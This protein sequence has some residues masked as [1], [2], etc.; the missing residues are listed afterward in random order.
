MLV[1]EDDPQVR[2][3][4]ARCC[5]SSATGCWRRAT[6]PTALRL[7][8]EGA[9]IDLL[10]ADVVLP[11]GMKGSE[12][13]RRMAE[14]RPGLRVLFMSGY[15]ENAIVHHG[16]LDD[17]VQLIGK[18]FQ[19]EHLARRV[20]EVLGR[21][22]ARRTPAAACAAPDRAGYSESPRATATADNVIDLAARARGTQA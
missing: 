19:R 18:P 8:A 15:T 2:E 22:A 16:R 3:V 10:L 14:L 11:G 13:A 1:L 5:G 9:P 20:A 21:P 6:G 17:G 4:T 12:A 7:A